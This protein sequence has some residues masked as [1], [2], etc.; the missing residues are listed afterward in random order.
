MA[1]FGDS[2]AIS[3]GEPA[4]AIGNPLGLDFS[5]TV[6]MGIISA[7]ERSIEVDGGWELNVIQTDAAINPGNSGGALVNVAGQVIGINSLKIAEHGY[8]S[9]LFG[10]SGTPVEGMGFAIPINDAIPIIKDLMAYGKV[11]RPFM[12]ME[13]MDLTSIDSYHWQNTLK[14]PSDVNQ[15]IVVTPVMSHV[16]SR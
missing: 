16:P 8:R 7:K 5:R 12:G 10:S 6:T 14:L 2:D 13:W 15:G 1:E 3:T 9:G 4:I 11:K